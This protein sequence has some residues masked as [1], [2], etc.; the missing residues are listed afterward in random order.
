MCYQNDKKFDYPTQSTPLST[1]TVERK[2]YK[3]I[4]KVPFCFHS[5]PICDVKENES[6]PFE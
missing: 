5:I 2:T 3:E 6:N 4:P 1:G